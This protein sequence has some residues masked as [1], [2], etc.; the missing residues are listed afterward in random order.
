MNSN[1]FFGNSNLGGKHYLHSSHARKIDDKRILK[2]CCKTY[3]ALPTSSCQHSLWDR[4]LMAI[5]INIIG[6]NWQWEGCES[7]FIIILLLF[8]HALLLLLDEKSVLTERLS[9]I[10]KDVFAVES[11]SWAEATFW[12]A[13]IAGSKICTK[14]RKHL[15]N[16]VLFAHCT[17]VCALKKILA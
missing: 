12:G 15:P 4:P 17:L 9:S 14:Y 11:Q 6:S 8:E 5:V 3:L 2:I 13:A 1:I 10:S 16:R 7:I